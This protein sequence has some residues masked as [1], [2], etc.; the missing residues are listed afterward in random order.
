MI[1]DEQSSK[2]ME[3][4]ECENRDNGKNVTPAAFRHNHPAYV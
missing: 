2:K 3:N 1:T 4:K